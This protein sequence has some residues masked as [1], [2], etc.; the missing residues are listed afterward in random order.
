MARDLAYK[1]LVT[2][3]NPCAFLTLR[4]ILHFVQDDKRDEGCV[5]RQCDQ[6]YLTVYECCFCRGRSNGCEHGEA[7]A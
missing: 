6:T 3:C 4:E 7:F 5:G 2:P 1:A